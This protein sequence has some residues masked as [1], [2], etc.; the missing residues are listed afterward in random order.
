MPFDP[1][2]EPALVF[3]ADWPDLNRDPTGMIQRIAAVDRL[4]EDVPRLYLQISFRRVFRHRINSFGN[5]RVESLN[6]FLHQHVVVDRLRRAPWVYVHSCMHAIKLFP[7]LPNLRS[8]LIV[9]L[10][11]VVPEE[12]DFLGQPILSKA[13]GFIER[14]V[15]R[16]SQCLVIVT[17]KLGQ[18][19]VDKYP[20]HADAARF[21]TLPNSNFR[22][23]QIGGWDRRE[24]SK[25]LR[26]IY[27]G[28]VNRWQK[29]DFMLQVLARLAKKRP[30]VHTRIFVPPVF[31][32]KIKAQVAQLGLDKL[33]QVDTRT[34]HAIVAEYSKADA[35][36]VLR[37]DILIN[38]VSMPTKM[39][40]YVN[41]GL[42]PIVLSPLIGDFPEYGYGY[43]TVEDLFDSAATEP[44]RL[45]EIRRGNLECLARIYKDS[46]QSADQ[47]RG[48]ILGECAAPAAASARR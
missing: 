8:K 15:V 17:R 25:Q 9:D 33:V 37:E 40:E 28:T 18:H 43:L 19:I 39:V 21:L 30:E 41:Y 1:Q 48:L 6:F 13:F 26:L 11:G 35:G 10:H 42:V 46:A 12:I 47:L 14:Q 4:F 7:H 24:G 22:G 29:V 34:A 2:F 31:L 23:K 44:G 45:E 3:I 36:F 38:R 5:A 16:Y 32:A 27:A 20:Q